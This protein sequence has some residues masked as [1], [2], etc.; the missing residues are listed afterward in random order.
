[1]NTL[2]KSLLSSL[3]LV[4]AGLSIPALAQVS[5]LPARG[6]ISFEHYDINKDGKISEDEFNKIRAKRMS[7]KSSQG[8]RMKN[9]T[10]SPS[11]AQFDGDGNGTLSKNELKLGQQK[12]QEKRLERMKK[13][14]KDMGQRKGMGQGRKGNMPSYAEFDLNGDGKLLEDEFNQARANRIAERAKQNYPMKNSAS[15]PSFSD[16]D[17]DGSGDV[18]AEEFAKHQVIHRKKRKLNN[19]Q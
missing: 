1:M 7:Q 4:F 14:K 18:S 17:L 13:R 11:F 19:N 15:M 8:K 6:P 12:Q 9:A 2:D 10:H 5:E 3:V 16:I